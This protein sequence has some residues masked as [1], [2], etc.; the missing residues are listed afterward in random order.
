[1]KDISV[2]IYLSIYA[3][4]GILKAIELIVLVQVRYLFTFQCHMAK[5]AISITWNLRRLHEALMARG[6]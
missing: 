2:I 1:M 4:S 6:I 3:I 5:A